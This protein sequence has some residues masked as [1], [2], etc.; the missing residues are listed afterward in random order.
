MDPQQPDKEILELER[1]ERRGATIMRSVY[2]ARSEGRKLPVAW[3][4]RGQPIDP[5]KDQF[6][7]F[8]GVIAREHVPITCEN[9][10]QLPQERI[11]AI[12]DEISVSWLIY[13]FISSFY[14]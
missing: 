14:R 4:R 2:I 10:K 3:N 6:V 9:F 7:G 8:I 13:C 11:Q 1:Q 5:G 12:W